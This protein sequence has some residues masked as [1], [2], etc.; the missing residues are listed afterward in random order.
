MSVENTRVASSGTAVV[1]NEATTSRFPPTSERASWE[2][3]QRRRACPRGVF[4]VCCTS[5]SQGR[6]ACQRGHDVYCREFLFREGQREGEVL[7][8]GRGGGRREG[9]CLSRCG[10]WDA[11]NE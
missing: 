10:T 1:G 2:A 5:E 3:T 9:L 4:S 6:D 7:G 11:P 8:R